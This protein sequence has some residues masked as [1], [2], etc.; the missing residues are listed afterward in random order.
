MMK[1]ALHGSVEVRRAPFG[2][3][4]ND[5]DAVKRLLLAEQARRATPWAWPQ[6]LA[7]RPD[8][9]IRRG[10]VPR[11]RRRASS[12]EPP[13]DEIVRGSGA[14]RRAILFRHRQRAMK[15]HDGYG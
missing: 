4:M 13:V 2:M 8:V 10:R 11:R 15:G 1:M 7:R 5:A 14:F 3:Q 12:D 9:R 6:R